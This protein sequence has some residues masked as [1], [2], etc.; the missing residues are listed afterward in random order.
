MVH[1]P[2]VGLLIQGGPKE[3][4]HVLALLRKRIPVILFGGKGLA[5]DIIAYALNAATETLVHRI[6]AD[7][8]F[9]IK[10]VISQ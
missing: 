6:F 4:D 8:N 9:S 7:K 3:I 2:L 5:A 1:T 10:I